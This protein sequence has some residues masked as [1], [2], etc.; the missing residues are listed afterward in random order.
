MF[1]SAPLLFRGGFLTLS[2]FRMA[3]WARQKYHVFQYNL[4]CNTLKQSQV[5]FAH[6]H[7]NWQHGPTDCLPL[8]R[9]TQLSHIFPCAIHI[10]RWVDRLPS[11]WSLAQAG[12]A[13]FSNTCVKYAWFIAR[14]IA[15]FV[16]RQD[17]SQNSS[18]SCVFKELVLSLEF[19]GFLFDTLG[20][21]MELPN[22][23]VPMYAQTQ[24]RARFLEKYCS[25]S[26][27]AHSCDGTVTQML[28]S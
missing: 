2:F 17:L 1:F 22:F 24:A 3:F 23:V 25:R 10:V 4:K 27:L 13:Y 26:G 12:N 18:G 28:P 14:Q 19:R 7:S 20:P 6:V 8:S 11:T 9:K 5:D 21:L 16:R 15:R